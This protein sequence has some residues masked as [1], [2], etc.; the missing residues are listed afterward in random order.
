MIKTITQD[1]LLKYVYCE[2]S[3]KQTEQIEFALRFD[4]D[5]KNDLLD[6]RFLKKEIQKIE[7]SPTQKLVDNLIFF[8]KNY[9]S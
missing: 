2:T 9:S 7:L 6:F 1:D 8:S 4:E 5:L 3:K